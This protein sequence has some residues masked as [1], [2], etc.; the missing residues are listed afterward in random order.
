MRP[1]F[2]N[3]SIVF[4]S[5]F[6]LAFILWIL[7]ISS[8][9]SFLLL[10]SLSTTSSTRPYDLGSV[11]LTALR[12]FCTPQAYPE[13]ETRFS[14]DI[15]PMPL[16]SCRDVLRHGSYQTWSGIVVED[17]A[18]KWSA[19]RTDKDVPKISRLRYDARIRYKLRMKPMSVGFIKL[20]AVERYGHTNSMQCFQ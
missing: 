7:S 10:H 9:I 16:K 3:I 4:F 20:S 18:M 19:Q 14:G 13:V 12:E 15:H 11:Y 8:G 1:S 6:C 2:F 5:S 17:R